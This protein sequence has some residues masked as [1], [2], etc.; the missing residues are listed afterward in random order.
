[1]RIPMKYDRYERFIDPNTEHVDA[2]IDAPALF[3]S[4]ELNEDARKSFEAY[5]GEI[6]SELP[7]LRTKDLDDNRW[8]RLLG[9]GFEAIEKGI[10]DGSIKISQGRAL[11]DLDSEVRQALEVPKGKRGFAM[12]PARG[13]PLEALGIEGF[14]VAHGKIRV[15][16]EGKVRGMPEKGFAKVVLPEVSSPDTDP[17]KYRDAIRVGGRSIFYEILRQQ[18]LQKARH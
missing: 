15:P 1:M 13:T 17:T 18:Q 5:R 7:Q 12:Y 8:Q 10:A 2:G 6:A 16:F 11:E 3:G 4:L 14:V 9:R